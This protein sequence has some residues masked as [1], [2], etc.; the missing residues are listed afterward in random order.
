MAWRQNQAFNNRQHEDQSM[1]D[2]LYRLA[3]LTGIIT[4]LAAVA[5]IGAV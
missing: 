3:G 1:I 5:M 4:L 2:F